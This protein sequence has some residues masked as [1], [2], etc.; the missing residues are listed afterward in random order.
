MFFDFSA[1]RNSYAIRYAIR[2][3]NR[4]APR[5]PA[6]ATDSGARMRNGCAAGGHDAPAPHFG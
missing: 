1:P 3:A 6:A 2:Y 4:Y 5:A